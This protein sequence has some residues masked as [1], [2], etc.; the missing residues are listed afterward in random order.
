MVDT[1]LDNF[2]QLD[3]L[4]CGAGVFWMGAAAMRSMQNKLQSKR[5]NPCGTKGRNTYGGKSEWNNK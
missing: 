5:G 2:C 1:V 3:I 4:A